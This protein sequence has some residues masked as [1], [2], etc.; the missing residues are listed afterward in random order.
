M[1]ANVITHVAP[2][3]AMHVTWCRTSAKLLAEQATGTRLYIVQAPPFAC[4][5]NMCAGTQ[6]QRQCVLVLSYA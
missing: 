3:C 4:G 1:V 2:V 5:G 6:A